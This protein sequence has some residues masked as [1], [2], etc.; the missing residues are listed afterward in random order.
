S[1]IGF[2]TASAWFGG[3]A[4]VGLAGVLARDSSLE[5]VGPFVLV[6]ALLMFAL[7]E[8]FLGVGESGK[9]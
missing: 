1:T 8:C 6:L 3:A 2:L 9:S 5:V 4:A 7:Y